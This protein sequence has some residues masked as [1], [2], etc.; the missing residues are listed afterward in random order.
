MVWLIDSLVPSETIKTSMDDPSTTNIPFLYGRATPEDCA[1]D[2]VHPQLKAMGNLQEI[3]GNMDLLAQQNQSKTKIWDFPGNMDD[4]AVVSMLLAVQFQKGTSGKIVWSW[5][6]TATKMVFFLV[7]ILGKMR[8]TPTT[9]GT[10][11]RY[12]TSIIQQY[13]CSAWIDL[14]GV[15][16]NN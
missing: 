2:M 12:Q 8:D 10:S 11:A 16:A 1:S 14:L 3:P 13:H 4:R 5:L 15:S 7:F 6:E 9:R